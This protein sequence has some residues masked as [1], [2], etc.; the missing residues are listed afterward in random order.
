MLGSELL[1][2]LKNFRYVEF[3]CGKIQPMIYTFE[4]GKSPLIIG[5]RGFI[6]AGPYR[7]APAPG[8]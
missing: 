6:F 4:T 7:I 2:R 5:V 1:R 8:R 3:S